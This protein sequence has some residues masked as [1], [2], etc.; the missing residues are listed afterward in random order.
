MYDILVYL[1][2]NCQR[3]EV[4]NEKERVAKKL[5]AAGFEESDISEALTWLAGV[6]RGPHRSFAPLPD[7]GAAF[8]AY[9]PKELAKLDAECRGLLIYFEQSGILTPQMREHV[10]E[11][12][13]AANGEGLS[14]EQLKLVVLM[15]L[16]NQQTP[17]SRLIAEELLSAATARVP[18]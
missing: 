14:I 13:L 7:S 12:A 17:S 6:A 10:I 4:C 9:A 2:E 3:H 16:W 15:V 8:R 18:S 5:S 11:R 1:F